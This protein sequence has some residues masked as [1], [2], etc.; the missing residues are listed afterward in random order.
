M[1]EQTDQRRRESKKKGRRNVFQKKTESEKHVSRTY[2][3]R[4]DGA[5][6]RQGCHSIKHSTQWIKPADPAT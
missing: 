2:R 5:S 6:F 1:G 4:Q 3:G